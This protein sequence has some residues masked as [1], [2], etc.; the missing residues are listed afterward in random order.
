VWCRILDVLPQHG[1]ILR[2]LV[3]KLPCPE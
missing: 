1:T 3:W 2:S